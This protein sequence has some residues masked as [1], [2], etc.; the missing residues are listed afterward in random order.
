MNSSKIFVRPHARC[1]QLCAGSVHAGSGD[2][3][4]PDACAERGHS[5]DAPSDRAGDSKQPGPHSGSR[6]IPR[7]GQRSGRRSRR[8]YA[9]S[10]HWLGRRLHL[11]ISFH[12]WR[13]APAIFQLNY[14]QNI[15][16]P[17]LKAQQ[18]A[19]EEHAKS[20][21]LEIDHMR[22]SVIVRTAET[23]LELAKVRHSL[24]LL[25]AEQVSAEKIVGVTRDRVA[26]NQELPI[27]ETRSE[28]T[29]ASVNEHI[30]KLEGRDAT[31]TEQ[32]RDL[33][34]LP[35]SDS[36]G[37]DRRP[38]FSTDLQASQ[39]ADL[40]MHSDPTIQEANN[41][42]DARQQFLAAR[43]CLFADSRVLRGI[44]YPQQIQQLRQLLPAQFVSA[45]Q[46]QRRRADQ[47]SPLLGKDPRERRA[48]KE[49]AR[50]IRAVLRQ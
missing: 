8:V 45:K 6:S 11:W 25:R 39:L 44:Q 30:L 19:A 16:N 10:L 37:R 18:R 29:A 47:Y 48:C 23:Y 1:P 49:P 33:T 40:A 7:R 32:L 13:A 3:V 46:H 41:D 2:I 31:L 17:V 27:E 43:S 34:G 5:D 15:F 42:R 22:D 4:R 26:A 21:K 35:D 38:S 20:M 28:L 24:D 36:R 12:R 50:A 9:E 14:Q